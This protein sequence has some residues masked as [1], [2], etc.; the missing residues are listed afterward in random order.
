MMLLSTAFLLIGA[1]FLGSVTS[2]IVEGTID[3]DIDETFQGSSLDSYFQI[4]INP[5]G[6]NFSESSFSLD[7]FEL[8]AE[9]PLFHLDES[10]YLHFA[11][12]AMRLATE[13]SG[14]RIKLMSSGDL[15]FEVH[16]KEIMSTSI[17]E[18]FEFSEGVHTDEDI[19]PNS[20]IKHVFTG[21][22]DIQMVE[23][24]WNLDNEHPD[25]SAS[26][27]LVFGFMTVKNGN[28]KTNLII[29]TKG[30]EINIAV[31][32]K[33]LNSTTGDKIERKTI[34]INLVTR[35]VPRDNEDPN[36]LHLQRNL[37]I[38]YNLGDRDDNNI[39][40]SAPT[41]TTTPGL[42][43]LDPVTLFFVAINEEKAIPLIESILQD[44]ENFI[45][46]TD[47]RCQLVNSALTSCRKG[48]HMSSN[49]DRGCV[50]VMLG[51]TTGLGCEYTTKELR[52]DL[53]SI[54]FGNWTKTLNA[55][56]IDIDDCLES[57]EHQWYI[58]AATVMLVG[59]LILIFGYLSFRV[60]SS[61]LK[62]KLL[63]SNQPG[64]DSS[65]GFSSKSEKEYGYRNVAYPFVIANEDDVKS[66]S[67][68]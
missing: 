41:T 8:T 3:S 29:P 2:D 40:T 22:K 21:S 46:M 34:E 36:H 18:N 7:I 61:K 20:R 57:V 17:E 63:Q 64:D 24:S 39:T 51:V 44:T 67:N 13:T 68:I 65:A 23:L 25:S 9:E 62:F 66:Y 55:S 49:P 10:R 53:S 14:F 32:S 37:R 56:R 60:I 35:K 58:F 1:L 27:P 19:P 48:C 4:E 16:Y 52:N 6:K 5:T 12:T 47:F 26:A 11:D 30:R 54:F 50:S 45:T 42:D 43:D 38:E 59:S 31:E 28:G 15:P 33:V